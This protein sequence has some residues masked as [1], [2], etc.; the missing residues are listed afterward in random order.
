MANSQLPMMTFTPAA[1][2]EHMANPGI[3]RETPTYTEGVPYVARARAGTLHLDVFND[4]FL[5]GLQ[6]MSN[7]KLDLVAVSVAR[8]AF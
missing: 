4:R 8:M 7:G 2:A 5:A 1:V 3:T 6:R